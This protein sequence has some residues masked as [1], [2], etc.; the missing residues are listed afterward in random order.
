MVSIQLFGQANE[1]LK[2]SHFSQVGKFGLL[3]L[4]FLLLVPAPWVPTSLHIGRPVIRSTVG[5]MAGLPEPM[6]DQHLPGG[7]WGG[8]TP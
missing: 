5:C 2:L 6:I 7:L 1:Y 3:S 4:L 8:Q